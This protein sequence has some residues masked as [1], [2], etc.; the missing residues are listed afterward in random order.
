MYV[1]ATPVAALMAVGVVSGL[2]RCRTARAELQM[3]S[4]FKHLAFQR[5]TL[6]L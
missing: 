2:R 1:A 4:G 6:Q 5:G 3:V